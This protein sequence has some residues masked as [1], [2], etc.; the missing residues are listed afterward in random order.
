MYNLDNQNKIRQKRPKKLNFF[1]GTTL[2]KSDF[3]R[4]K[5]L[6]FMYERGITEIHP[7]KN[8]LNPS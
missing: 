8:L 2:N 5:H 4:H 6:E 7:I 1:K 3:E